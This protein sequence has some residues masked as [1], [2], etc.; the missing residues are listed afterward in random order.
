MVVVGAAP[1]HRDRSMGGPA[2]TVTGV[3]GRSLSFFVRGSKIRSGPH[4]TTGMT[5][6][7]VTSHN[8][9]TPVLPRI[10]HRSGSLVVVPSG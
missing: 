1:A 7:P 6:A 2:I 5:G 10:G 8:R 4:M 9:A 3:P